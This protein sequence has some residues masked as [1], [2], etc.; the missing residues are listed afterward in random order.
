MSEMERTEVITMPIMGRCKG[1][2]K[3]KSDKIANGQLQNMEHIL[4]TVRADW[5]RTL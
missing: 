4:E 3:V 2:T 1:S 5:T